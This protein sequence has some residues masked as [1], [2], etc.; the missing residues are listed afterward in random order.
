MKTP[1]Q[2]HNAYELL[3]RSVVDYAIYLLDREGRVASWNPGAERIKGYAAADIL[4]EHFSRFYTEEDRRAG[5]PRTALN[6]AAETGRYSAEGWRVRKDGTR[7][8]ALIVID[9][10]RDAAGEVIGFAKITRDIS[11]RREAELRALE[12]ERSFRLLVQGVTDYAIYML[13]PGGRVTSWNMGAERI[14]G[15]IAADIVGEHFSRFYTPED[16]DSGLPWAALETARRDGRYEAEGW[17]VRKDGTRFWASAVIDAVRDDDG[18][19]VGFA[20]ITRDMT[21]RREAQLRLEDSREQLFQ[22]QKMEALGQLTGGIAHDFN[23]LLTAILGAADIASRHLGNP[24]KLQRMMDGIQNSARRGGELTK[25][26]LAFAR[27]RPLEP[28]LIDLDEQLP[29]L[30]GLLHSSLRGNIEMVTEFE[31]ELW[32]IEADPSQLELSL[33][34]L[35]VNARDAMPAGGQ[36]RFAARNVVLA[37]E[38][39]GH[40][41]D[42]A[43][44]SVEDTG[45]GIPAEIRPRIFEPFFTTKQ[46]GQGTGLG[47]AQVYGFAQQ[48][49]GA[50]TVQSAE[51]RGTTMTLYLPSRGV[52]ATSRS[53]Q[54]SETAPKSSVLVVE[55]DPFLAELAADLVREIGYESHVAHSAAEALAKLSRIPGIQL[56]FSDVIMPG[57]MSGL[58]L[59][60]KVR[61]RY[62]ELPIVLTTG[63]SEAVG[64]APDEFPVIPKPYDVRQ[65]ASSLGEFMTA[66]ARAGRGPRTKQ[67]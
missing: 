18:Q 48:S 59:A 10:V 58:E 37:G 2:A 41:G 45:T 62:P 30:A 23:N 67:V 17:R 51:G 31:P 66:R 21:E 40:V 13:D 9:A 36:L 22:S 24:E 65:L 42:Y 49:K 11:E 64:S 44:I 38:I 26:L 55:D 5:V 53:R 43:A 12:S 6:T 25:Q 56:V 33:L 14:E 7:F 3:V 46:F 32:S 57:G 47:L 34:N 16:R 28:K 60:R 15:Y 54:G 19:L 39:E 1:F 27:R 63:Y 50:V 20:K 61:V 29:A 52:A 4:G 8:W 35:A